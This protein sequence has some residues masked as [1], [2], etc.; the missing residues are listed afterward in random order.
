[1]TIDILKDSWAA[2][3]IDEYKKS[4]TEAKL[5]LQWPYDFPNDPTGQLEHLRKIN[6]ITNGN[7]GIVITSIARQLVTTRENKKTV[8][9]EYLTVR[10]EARATT[11]KGIPYAFAFELGR[12]DKPNVVG[13]MN[14][15]YDPQTGDP[16]KP[17]FVISGQSSHYDTKYLCPK[18]KAA[19]KK[20]IDSII[21]DNDPEGIK[22]Y[23]KDHDRGLRD[24]SYPYEDLVNCSIEELRNMSAKG[25]GSRSPG[26]WRDP[27][28][29]KIKDRDGNLVQ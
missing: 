18:D 29:G 15:Q 16:L 7:P 8:K 2:R 14:Q 22:Y 21:G 24:P 20:L 23:Y 11:H 10:G 6:A 9:K 19:R 3:T 25:G 5:V 27:K 17:E 1:L 28:D 13:N 12:Y 4:A 26:I